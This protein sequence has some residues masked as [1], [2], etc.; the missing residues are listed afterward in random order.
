[1]TNT[2]EIKSEETGADAPIA[3]ETKPTVGPEIEIVD[4]G[5]TKVARPKQE[6]TEDR[7][8][9]LPEKFKSVED[10][11][12]AY[13][14]LEKKLGQPKQAE[15]LKEDENKQSDSKEPEEG[16]KEGEKSEDQTEAPKTHNLA[17]FSEEWAEK[18][19]LSEDS[20]KELQKLGY[21]QE[22]VDTYIE[23]FQA[24]Q[25]RQVGEVYKT[26]GGEENYKAMI[27]WASANLPENEV[28]SYDNIVT[29]ND[30]SQ[31]KLAVKGLWAQ[32]TEAN[33]K[34]PKLIGGSQSGVSSVTPFR[35]TAEVVKAMSD[36][37][38]SSDSAYRKDVEKR[39]EFS[40]VL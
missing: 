10:L 20:Y 8:E 14:E 39:L 38:Y 30:P 21:P 24:L 4:Q 40:D 7:P 22:F 5:G 32:Y 35:S 27:E 28:E 31:A 11:A 16:E 23:G 37:R 15:E 12:K 33:G 26:V 25:D 19:E 13:S 1:M 36:P 29:S 2:V 17:K 34:Q 18:G 9:A 3:E 6:N